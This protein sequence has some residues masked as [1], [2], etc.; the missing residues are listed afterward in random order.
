METRQFVPAGIRQKN[1]PPGTEIGFIEIHNERGE[2]V[3]GFTIKSKLTPEQ[4]REWIISEA[5][6]LCKV[7]KSGKK[8]ERGETGGKFGKPIGHSFQLTQNDYHGGH[9]Y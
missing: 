7:D 9:E 6:R 2:V 4:E 8:L 3:A 1:P 5:D